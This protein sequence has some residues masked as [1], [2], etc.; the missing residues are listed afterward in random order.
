MINQPPDRICLIKLMPS[1]AHAPSITELENT[2]C[3]KEPSNISTRGLDSQ[4]EEERESKLTQRSQE[5][6]ETEN[7]QHHVYPNSKI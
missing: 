6:I 4:S 2:G 7:H 1:A 3:P 5:V